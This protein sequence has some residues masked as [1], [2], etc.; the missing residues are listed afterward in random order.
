M[1]TASRGG[2]NSR[3]RRARFPPSLRTMAQGQPLVQDFF[4]VLRL[5]AY[6]RSAGKCESPVDI[7]RWLYRETVQKY[8]AKYGM[9]GMYPS[10][11]YAICRVLSEAG[12]KLS[13]RF[14]LIF[15]DE[16]QDISA[17]EYELLRRIHWD[18]AFN[19][20]GDLKQNVT[21]FR[22]VRDW[23]SALEGNVYELNRNYRNTNEIVD[24]VSGILDVDMV[25]IGFHGDPVR[26]IG[27]RQMNGFFRGKQGLKAVIAREELLE[28]LAARRGYQL[29]SA[30]GKISKTK[31][32]VMTVYESKGLE[33]SCVAVFDKGMTENE[34][35]I[36]YTRALRELA[37]VREG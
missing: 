21:P 14:G 10:D 32:N 20:F 17:E 13:P 2:R 16:G 26:E 11:G 37:V 3:R 30:S 28:T 25:P 31:I 22:G 5:S 24:F 4:G 1:P 18:A 35:Y 36:A 34:K 8:K 33:F 7:V 6:C 29:L 12:R 19:V 23:K 27:L 15:I 9:K